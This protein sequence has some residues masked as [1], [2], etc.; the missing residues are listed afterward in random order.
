[1]ID[2]YKNADSWISNHN[3]SKSSYNNLEQLLISNNL[4]KNPIPFNKI[5]VNE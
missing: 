5:V 2:N 3:I 1:M 4:I